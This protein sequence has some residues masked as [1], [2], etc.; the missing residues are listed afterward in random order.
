MAKL[1]IVAVSW[2]AIGA[3]LGSATAADEKLYT[4]C[5]PMDSVV[6]QLDPED[7]QA[8]GLTKE[9]IENAVESRLRAARLFAPTAEQTNDKEQFLYINVNIM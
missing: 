5:A 7:L 2:L 3:M 8:I 6:E 4:A 1:L 9:D